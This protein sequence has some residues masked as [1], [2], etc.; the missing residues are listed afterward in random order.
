MNEEQKQIIAKSI[1]RR[2]GKRKGF[3]QIRN[4]AHR[5][6]YRED[7]LQ[8]QQREF[9]DV[10]KKSMMIK[11]ATDK[12]Y[13]KETLRNQKELDDIYRNK[14]KNV[15]TYEQKLLRDI[16]RERPR[17]MSEEDIIRWQ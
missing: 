16:H 1:E 3:K 15:L 5:Q 7:I 9:R 13:E 2:Y 14:P 6:L 10:Y 12:R 11:E 17:M 8:P 4:A